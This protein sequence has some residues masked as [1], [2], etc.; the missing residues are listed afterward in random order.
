MTWQQR[1]AEDNWANELGIEIDQL[2]STET[3]LFLPFIKRNLQSD[4]GVIHGGIIG[5]LLHDSGLLVAAESITTSDHDLLRCVDFQANYLKAAKDCDLMASA[6]IIR[7]GRNYLFIQA[8]VTDPKNHIVASARMVF[9]LTHAQQKTQAI[10]PY[11][12]SEKLT[13][14]LAKP[15]ELD[16]LSGSM[17]ERRPGFALEGAEGGLCQV[18]MADLAE[19]QNAQGEIAIGAQIFAADTAGVFAY[20]SANGQV[21]QVATIDLKLTFCA[22]VKG[23]GLSVVAE[24]LLLNTGLV[25]HQLS[26]FGATSKDLKAFGTM[27][28]A[29]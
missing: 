10:Q 1:Y 18:S 8:E 12:A 13:A 21:T 14:R 26:I 28:L 5:S 2:S 24:S 27:T 19:N 3:Q 20:F 16:M 25:H 9:A 11:L 17:V 7:K 15:A 23:E 6:Q 4:E 22:P 29:I